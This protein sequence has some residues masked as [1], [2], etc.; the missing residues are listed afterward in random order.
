[1]EKLYDN[2]LFD[3]NEVWIEKHLGDIQYVCE[4]CGVYKATKSRCNKCEKEE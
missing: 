3:N 2:Y 4:F 1:M